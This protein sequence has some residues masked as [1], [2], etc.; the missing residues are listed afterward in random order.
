MIFST[1]CL[2]DKQSETNKLMCGLIL[3]LKVNISLHC[4]LCV[5]FYNNREWIILLIFLS[6]LKNFTK[7]FSNGSRL[8][9]VYVN[10]IAEAN[11]H[12]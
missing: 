2:G 8:P 7:H 11:A 12:H 1:T 10:S 3:S 5:S 9:S 6:G 4:S